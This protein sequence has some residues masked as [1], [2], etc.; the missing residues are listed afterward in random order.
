MSIEFEDLPPDMQEQAKKQLTEQGINSTLCHLDEARAGIAQETGSEHYNKYK[1]ASKSRRTYN[2]K[3]YH[4]RRE[5]LYASEV[6]ALRKAAGE[7][8]FWLE[9]VP[10]RLPGGTTY[11]L[12]YMT[13]KYDTMIFSEKLVYLIHNI[14]VKGKRIPLGELK[15]KQ[16]E[17]LYHIKIEVV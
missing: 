11:R 12:D 13:F 2:G 5:M 15:R 6:L 4:S 8:D 10:F 7:I 3:V 9:Q 14:E 16:C 17:E 1:V